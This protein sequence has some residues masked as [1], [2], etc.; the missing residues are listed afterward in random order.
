ME[1]VEVCL[2]PKDDFYAL[3]YKNSEVSRK[4]IKMLS[5]NL[6][7]K[8]EQLLKFAYNSVRKKVADALVTLYDRYKN[9]ADKNFTISISREDLAN[10][11]GIATESTIRTLSDFKEEKLIEINVS[12]ITI[13]NY[14]K[15]SK[16]HN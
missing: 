16:I 9:E 6:R 2:I 11:A 5:D 7:D 8:E 3:V 10:L 12:K 4:F 14:E 13:L 1:D 15:L